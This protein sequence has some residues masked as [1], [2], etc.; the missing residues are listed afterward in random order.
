MSLFRVQWCFKTVSGD[1]NSSA[2][3]EVKAS[4][5][6]HEKWTEVSD[7]TRILVYS[8]GYPMVGDLEVWLVID[9]NISTLKF[10]IVDY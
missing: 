1:E 2:M 9:C 7:S 5:G 8:S 6:Q 4:T 10:F 3:V